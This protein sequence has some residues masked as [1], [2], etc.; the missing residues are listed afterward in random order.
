MQVNL[1][2]HG[3]TLKHSKIQKRQ[4]QYAL[5]YIQAFN[6]ELDKMNRE[7]IMLEPITSSLIEEIRDK[8]VDHLDPEKLILFGSAIREGSNPHD[9]DIYVI[10]RGIYNVRE[11]ERKI[12]EL[13]AGR[14]FA[15]DVIVR[16]PEQVENSVK[17]GN[18][19][20]L[21]EVMTKGRVLYD[22]SGS[23]I[24]IS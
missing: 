1:L 4:E 18:S 22:K 23:K 17:S 7:K 12:D 14:L 6:E 10:K 13:F 21:R 5:P 8:I 3:Q 19:F 24:S 20:L 11:T 15:L 2:Q 16:T 9:I